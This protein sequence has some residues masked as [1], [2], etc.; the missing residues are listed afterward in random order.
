[1][2]SYIHF[3]ILIASFLIG[4]LIIH[5]SDPEIEKVEVYPTP[6]NQKEVQYKDKAGNCYQYQIKPT[7]CTL[8]YT[9]VPIQA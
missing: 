4:L 2:L 9:S 6:Y 8:K 5:Y 1:M 3:P 7:E